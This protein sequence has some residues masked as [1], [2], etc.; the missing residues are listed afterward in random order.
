MNMLEGLRAEVHAAV[1]VERE[2]EAPEERDDEAAILRSFVRYYSA[3]LKVLAPPEDDVGYGAAIGKWVQSTEGGK[4]K[5]CRMSSDLISAFHG[6]WEKYYF[7][8][9]WEDGRFFVRYGN[10]SELHMSQIN[11]WWCCNVPEKR[12]RHPAAPIVEAWVGAVT[13]GPPVD[14]WY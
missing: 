8:W 10:D 2:F 13:H 7:E 6:D 5:A 12:Q 9:V 14:S 4:S 1:F 11:R 3:K